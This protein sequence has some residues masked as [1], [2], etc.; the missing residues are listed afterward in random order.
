[1]GLPN[2]CTSRPLRDAVWRLRET[3]GSLHALRPL[4][5]PPV[6]PA[7]LLVF[8]PRLPIW[9]LQGQPR[10]RGLHPLPHQQPDHFRRGDQL[11]LPQR[12]LQSRPGPPGH[13]LHKYVRGLSGAMPDRVPSPRA[14]S[15][16]RG[17]DSRRAAASLSREGSSQSPDGRGNEKLFGKGPSW[18]GCIAHKQRPWSWHLAPYLLLPVTWRIKSRSRFTK[19]Q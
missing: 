13:A 9:N 14:G 2:N 11:R 5:P 8:C 18:G 4:S 6:S 1:M 15:S 10:G 3:A 19:G 17:L 16:E 7:I 12:L